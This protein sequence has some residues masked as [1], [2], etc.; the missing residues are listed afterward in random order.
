MERANRIGARAAVILGEDDIANGVAQVK[1]LDHGCAGGGAAGPRP[2]PP[3]MT[4]AL[5]LDRIAARAEE[6]RALL[7]E[8]I[9]GEAYVKASKELSDI[10]P[11]VAR[12][13]DLR[14]A[15]R[16]RDEAEVAAG[17]P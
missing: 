6:L 14:A 16:A 2:R 3:A 11:V 5:K 10:E 12:I 1:D 7:S 13:G 9:S 15:E 8:G 17:R 4:L